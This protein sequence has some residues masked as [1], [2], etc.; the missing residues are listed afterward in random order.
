MIKSVASRF[1][2]RHVIIVCDRGMVSE[3]N[4]RQL[5]AAFRTLKSELEMGPIYHY[6]ERKIR[7]VLSC[8]P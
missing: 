7:Q 4:I 8:G 5:E 1:K 2:T 3:K 6:T